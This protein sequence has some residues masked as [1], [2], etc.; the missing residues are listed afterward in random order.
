[1]LKRTEN[2][3]LDDRFDGTLLDKNLF[4]SYNG[5]LRFEIGPPFVGTKNVEKYVEFAYLRS[6][7]IFEDIFEN[8]DDIYIIAETYYYG[9]EPNEEY[10]KSLL[11]EIKKEYSSL[12]KNKH[13]ENICD[14]SP[15]VTCEEEG[16][17]DVA[18]RSVLEC[19]IKDIHSKKILKSII[20][21]EMGLESYFN[22]I[23]IIVNKNKNIAYYLYDDR[24]LDIISKDV[25]SLR[26]IYEKYNSWIL[27]YNRKE[28]DDI[29]KIQN[30]S[31]LHSLS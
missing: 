16:C 13:L 4:D 6:S 10:C 22:G 2:I 25:D 5:W 24:G 28:I 30:K 17:Y 26:S 20:N 8:E 9:D 27:D 23:I 14:F 3:N 21:L 15:I 7:M 31:V 29:F 11:P 18:F 1:M 12:I 19:K